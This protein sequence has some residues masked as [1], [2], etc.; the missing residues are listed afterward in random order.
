MRGW[1]RRTPARG[2]PRPPALPQSHAGR[3]RTHGPRVALVPG[4]VWLAFALAGCA[5]LRPPAPDVARAA[6][7][8]PSYSASLRVNLSGGGLRGR[9]RVLLAFA[10]PDA[11]RVEVPGPGGVRLLAV[12]RDGR[13]WAVFPGE[14]AWFEG[15]AGPEQME[16]LLGLALAPAEVMDL[17]LGRPAPRLRA[18]RAGWDA[19]LPRRVEATLPDGSRLSVKVDQVEAPAALPSAAF[20][21]PAHPGYRR[22]TADE[23]RSLWS[24]R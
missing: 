3:R 1:L 10:R 11:L 20:E 12:A 5:H 7:A 19:R 21:E 22:L 24:A 9:G 18:F 14:A 8:L 16:A 6:H 2:G 13:L 4:F 17:L 23:A 15:P